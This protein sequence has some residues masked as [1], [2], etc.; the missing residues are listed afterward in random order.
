MCTVIGH[1]LLDAK[2]DQ[3][4]SPI[5]VD[6]K[7]GVA[8][9][10]ATAITRQQVKAMGNASIAYIPLELEKSLAVLRIQ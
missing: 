5:C 3:V 1:L 6:G 8:A 7:C 4:V 2:I 9:T 10:G